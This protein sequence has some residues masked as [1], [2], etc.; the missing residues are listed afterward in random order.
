MLYVSETF[1]ER[2]ILRVVIHATRSTTWIES[3]LCGSLYALPKSVQIN[4]SLSGR[5]AARKVSLKSPRIFHDPIDYII[6]LDERLGLKRT[7][8]YPTHNSQ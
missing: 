8:I 4:I 3:R 1:S 6:D 5:T 2:P 7:A